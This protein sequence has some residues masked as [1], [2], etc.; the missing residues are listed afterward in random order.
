MPKYEKRKLK[1]GRGRRASK[2]I[3]LSINYSACV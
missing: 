2:A 3:R 1:K